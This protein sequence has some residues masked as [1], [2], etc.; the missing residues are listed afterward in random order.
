MFPHRENFRA[1][2]PSTVTPRRPDPGDQAGRVAHLSRPVKVVVAV[3]L[4]A[5]LTLG[6]A[7]AGGAKTKRHVRQS[8]TLITSKPVSAPGVDGTAYAIKYWSKSVRNRP[9]SVTGLVFVPFGTAPPGGWP[10]VSYGHATNGMANVCA[11]SL[12]PTNAVPAINDLLGRGWEVT[13]TDYQGEGNQN[14]APTSRGLQPHGA[15]VS[16]AHN[17][18]DIVRAASSVAGADPSSNYVV[19]GHSQGGGAAVFS[20]ELAA[21]YA[22]DLHLLGAVASAPP[23][24]LSSDFFGAPS[25]SASPFTLM[26]VAGYHA[27]YGN[28]VPFSLLTTTGKRLESHLGSECYDSIAQAISPYQVD[29][30]FST[31]TLP[32]KFSGLL[33]ANDPLYLNTRSASPLLVVQGLDDTTDLPSDTQAMTNHL[34]V[35]DHQDVVQWMYSGLDHNSIVSGSA[36]DVEHWIADRFASRPNP[37]SYSP[38][39]AQASTCN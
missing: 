24:H 35:A 11:P 13:A 19:W 5:A 1:S 37:D 20:L 4:I 2:V 29:Q 32:P 17:I 8:G 9:Q 23:T 16:E 27:A 28:K 34:C 33:N 12:D 26:Y 36:G 31:T 6:V 21:S 30:V 39:G 14:L 15:N 18:I 38:G 10:V 22:P 3:F 25:D 7:S